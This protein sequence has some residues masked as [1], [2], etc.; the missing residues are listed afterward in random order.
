MFLFLV[1]LTARIQHSL[2]V[3]HVAIIT[4]NENTKQTYE[5]WGEREPCDPRPRPSP[6]SEGRDA[7]DLDDPSVRG[8]GQVGRGRPHPVEGG[9]SVDRF[10]VHL[11]VE[12]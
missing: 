9:A 10:L 12:W 1:K 6:T 5:Y 3:E 7:G 11:F 4:R 8:V 2:S